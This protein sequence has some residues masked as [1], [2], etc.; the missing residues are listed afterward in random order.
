MTNQPTE[1]KTRSAIA[2]ILRYGS[3]ASTLVMALGL[4]LILVRGAVATPGSDLPILPR[5]LLPRLVH[6][7]PLAIT[8]SGILLLLLT[9]IFRIIVAAVSFGLE[10]NYRYVWI[11]LGVL[12]VI[13]GSI[14]FAM[15]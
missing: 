10:R 12:A 6:F 9:P 13:F 14:G 15:K 7:D 1:E 4:L 3:L 8:E 11:S 5:M 2:L